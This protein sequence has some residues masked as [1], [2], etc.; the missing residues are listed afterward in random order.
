MSKQKNVELSE[1]EKPE[2]T[3]NL[4]E[5]SE[6]EGI[7]T[8]EKEPEKVEAKVEKI[9][10]STPEIEKPVKVAKINKVTTAAVKGNKKMGVAKF[11]SYYPQDIYIEA[12]LKL[13]YPR[14]FFT[15][16][17]WFLRIEEILNMPIY[18]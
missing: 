9:V 18:N 4:I 10:E 8:P 11:L 1:T 15:V 12:L 6:L 13:Y 7:S 14:S 2:V 3:E 16:D 17:E 5:Q